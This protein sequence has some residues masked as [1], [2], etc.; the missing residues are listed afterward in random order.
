MLDDADSTVRKQPTNL[1]HLGEVRVEFSRAAFTG[2]D[3]KPT[4]SSGSS[5]NQ[6]EEITEKML[7]GKAISQKTW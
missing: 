3:D 7:K 5:F 2:Q 4:P 6:V 1:Q